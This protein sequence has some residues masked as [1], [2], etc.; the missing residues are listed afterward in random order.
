MLDQITPILLTLNEEANL[1]RTLSALQWAHRIVVIDSGS[2]DATC[3]IAKSFPNVDLLTRP[4]DSHAGQWNFAISHAKTEWVIAL[5][6]DYI[7][8]P[9]LAAEIQELPRRAAVSAYRAAFT[10]VNLGRP[11][12]GSLYP[13]K[14]V[15][16]RRQSARYFQDGH[17]QQIRIDGEIG[18]L[19]HHLLH[20]DRKPF[21]RWLDSQWRYA[22]L[23]AAKL[24]GSEAKQLPPADRLRKAV[25]L[26]PFLAPFF[27]LFVR[28]AILDGWP[29]I[30]YAFQRTV[31]E[32][33][34]SICLIQ[35]RF[36][37]DTNISA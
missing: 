14:P 15:L 28:K 16:F 36:R 3:T 2:T 33:V 9:E 32:A 21:G 1:R 19:H 31:A 17:T 30:H 25:F 27:V 11:L 34:L 10:Y 18:D 26:T 37:T 29:G 8:T 24:A 5:D 4:F 6:A 7:V 20:D 13:A 35:S 22:R 23:E 12:R